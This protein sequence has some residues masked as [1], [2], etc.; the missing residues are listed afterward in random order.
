[1]FV[2]VNNEEQR[3]IL[4]CS[5]WLAFVI[6]GNESCAVL[7]S[8]WRT[9]RTF[10]G[11]GDVFTSCLIIVVMLF[12]SWTVALGNN[13][14]PEGTSG[15]HH[16]DDEWKR[17]SVDR[18]WRH[19]IRH[20]RR[21]LYQQKRIGCRWPVRTVSVLLPWL[22]R[23]ADLP[24]LVRGVPRVPGSSRL[25]TRCGSQYFDHSR[26]DQTKYGQRDKHNTRWA[27]DLGRADHARIL[28]FR[29]AVL[30]HPRNGSIPW[31]RF[32]IRREIPPDIR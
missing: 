14:R 26:T 19:R 18:I 9:V 12:N 25:Y 8:S 17:N 23:A 15:R 24:Q 7:W 30:R 28:T 32:H 29:F 22:R 10:L 11:R 31:Q 6:Y 27:G 20:N 21:L 5:G 16:N 4:R 2:A 13:G 1:M 3:E